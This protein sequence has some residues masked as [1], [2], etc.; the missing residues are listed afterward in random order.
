MGSTSSSME[1]NFTSLESTDKILDL[2]SLKKNGM[3]YLLGDKLILGPNPK[4]LESQTGK[5]GHTDISLKQTKKPKYFNN[6]QYKNF[7]YYRGSHNDGTRFLIVVAFNDILAKNFINKGIKY[8][9]QIYIEYLTSACSPD[10]SY[11]LTYTCCIF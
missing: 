5:S 3:F 4:Y 7:R 6:H 8:Y 10:K 2:Y 1:N 11:E 9:V